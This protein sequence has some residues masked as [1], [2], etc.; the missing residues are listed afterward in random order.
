MAKEGG[1]SSSSRKGGGGRFS[2]SLS[3]GTRGSRR[4]PR[5]GGGQREFPCFPFLSFL[6][7]LRFFLG[8]EVG[9]EDKD[10]FDSYARDWVGFKG[11]RDYNASP[12]FP[13]SPQEVKEKG[14][15]FTCM[16]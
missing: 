13:L 1:S 7:F 3:A 10:G 16:S 2:C 9:V 6:S 15:G 5:N 11:F 8:E 12:F 14:V 4:T